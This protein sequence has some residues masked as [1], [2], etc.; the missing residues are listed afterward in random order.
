MG[1]PTQVIF[2]LNLQ[3]DSAIDYRHRVEMS[4]L[5]LEYGIPFPNSIE[6]S[7][8]CSIEASKEE[9]L[10]RVHVMG[11]VGD[12]GAMEELKWNIRYTIPLGK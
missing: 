9:A 1:S 5:I 4:M 11:L 3:R 8:R 7:V 6:L 12:L 2:N 10:D